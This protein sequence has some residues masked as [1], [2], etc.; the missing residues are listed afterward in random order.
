MVSSDLTATVSFEQ[1]AAI[2]SLLATTSLAKA[3][4]VV[5]AGG[6][7]GGIGAFQHA[8]YVRELP[9]LRN[10]DVRA[11]PLCGWFFPNV[12]NYSAWEQNP[13][14]GFNWGKVDKPGLWTDPVRAPT[15]MLRQSARLAQLGFR[16]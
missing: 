7:A 11:T 16:S 14:A 1:A 4:K 13:E 15:S 9:Q 8:D 5:V 3:E 6:S 2:S 10:A 12:G